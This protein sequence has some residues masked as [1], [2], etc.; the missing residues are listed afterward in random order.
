MRP[1]QGLMPPNG[2]RHYDSTTKIT[3]EGS[4]WED[5]ARK[6]EGYRRANGMH[7][8]SPIEEIVTKFCSEFPHYCFK[9]DRNQVF[10]AMQ[11]T[12][13]GFGNR[14]VGWVSTTVSRVHLLRRVS[15][16]NAN[17]RAAICAQCPRQQDWTTSCGCSVGQVS[18]LKGYVFK[19]LG[20]SETN[21]TR[22]LRACGALAE[23]TSV[24]VWLEQPPVN[25]G[26]PE[27]C[28]RLRS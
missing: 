21:A 18:Q 8:G 4:S 28:W 12:D 26:Q 13:L 6:L 1:T 3:F 25:S 7:V 20:V 24:S 14:V 19:S 5:V 27:N 9:A 15:E 11:H 10:A 17:A 22:P 23:E 16:H 2:F